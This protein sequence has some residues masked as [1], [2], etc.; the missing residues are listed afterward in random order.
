VVVRNR[1]LVLADAD[2]LA[3]DARSEAA[4]L[5]DRVDSIPEHAFDPRMAAVP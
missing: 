4:R 3:A 2:R 5:W 1:E